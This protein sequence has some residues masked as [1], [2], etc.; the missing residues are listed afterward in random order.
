VA[1]RNDEAMKIT[2]RRLRRIIREELS[3][4]IEGDVL[5]WNPHGIKSPVEV[6]PRYPDV[7]GGMSSVVPPE[8]ELV[9]FSAERQRRGDDG[10]GELVGPPPGM[11][12]VVRDFEYEKE[13]GYPEKDIVGDI[14]LNPN[15]PLGHPNHIDPY[16]MN[17]RDPG[18]AIFNA[19]SALAEMGI[20][21]STKV[22]VIEDGGGYFHTVMFGTLKDALNGVV[23]HGRWQ[24]SDQEHNFEIL[25][26]DE[27][28]GGIES[29]EEAHVPFISLGS[30]LV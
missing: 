22:G 23:P 1:N 25:Y 12:R 15:P 2:K 5:Q 20:P 26:V 21:M 29:I 8:G 11:R 17:F 24:E 27:S 30:V 6:Q 7:I 10:S 16:E 13:H 19:A 14:E 4:V 3:R 9:D 28:A 18:M